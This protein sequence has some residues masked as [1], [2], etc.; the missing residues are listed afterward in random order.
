MKKLGLLLLVALTVSCCETTQDTENFYYEEQF[1]LV[2]RTLK[3]KVIDGNTKNVRTWIIQRVIVE[4]D[5]L[6]IGEIN[7]AGCSCGIITNELWEQRKVGDTLYFEYIRKDRFEL[8]DN[9]LSPAPDIELISSPIYITSE[10]IKATTVI[11]LNKLETERRVLEIERQ[12]LSL[13]RELETL[14][15]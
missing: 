3:E 4:S 14:K 11:N 12:I 13:E 9:G 15:E 1:V 5:S 2:D 7:D 10:E 6:M 8:S